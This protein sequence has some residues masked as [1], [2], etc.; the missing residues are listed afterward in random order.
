MTEI[1]AKTTTAHSM[2]DQLQEFYN[3]L[4]TNMGMVYWLMMMSVFAA[5][6]HSVIIGG[7]YEIN[8]RPKWFFYVANPL[9]IFAAAQYDPR[10]GFAVAIGLF[11]SV[12]VLGIIGMFYS[13]G[14]DALRVQRK[15][16]ER[17][18]K[19]GKKP[20]P[21]WLL[22]ILAIASVIFA[23]GFAIAGPYTILLVVFV[24]PF[25][26]ALKPSNEKSFYTLQRTLPTA[27]IRSVAMGLAE[28][29]GKVRIIEQTIAPI[30]KKPCAGYY[31]TIESI[32]KDSDGDESFSLEDSEFECKE[33]Y[34]ED[35]T[36]RIKIKPDKLAFIDFEVDEQ[37]RSHGARYTQYLLEDGMEVLMIG[38]ASV[39]E[40]NERVFERE[41]IKKVFG[42]AYA[43]TVQQK[44]DWW[45][46]RTSAI[47]FA[48][49]WVIM[50]AL[51]LM[52][53]IEIRNNTIEF[54]K[55][56]WTPTFLQHNDN[57]TDEGT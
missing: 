6:F 21:T 24:I 51:I 16:N 22:P 32:S 36:G 54:G 46:M 3:G 5:L 42:I 1:T 56:Q 25:L 55:I 2:P 49:A 20:F 8:I 31:Y 48:Y 33:F 53:P 44:N 47:L 19:D 28:I 50:I 11:L 14:R 23:L 18:K 7:L 38:K 37:Y 17:R 30:K 57:N 27:P 10:M 43:K 45:P 29:S 41:E 52:T 34:V 12:F 13:A 35:R 15:N 39:A 40:N 26:S 4:P 9:A